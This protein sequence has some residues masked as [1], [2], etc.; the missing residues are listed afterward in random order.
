MTLLEG[1]VALVIT[2]LA[3]VG[4][5]GVYQQGARATHDRA[6]WGAVVAYA[7]AGMEAAKAGGAALQEAQ[8]EQ[9][10]GLRRR[11][12]RQRW[13]GALDELVVTVEGRDGQ[14]LRLSRLSAREAR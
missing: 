7:E 13:Q 3:A 10:E 1:I 2:G 4:F 6:T 5:L 9:R 11:I 12:E 8:H 14:V